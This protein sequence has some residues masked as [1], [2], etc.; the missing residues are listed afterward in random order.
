[1]AF[2]TLLVLWDLVVFRRFDWRLLAMMMLAAVLAVGR[3]PD[4]DGAP[5]PKNRRK[6]FVSMGLLGGAI[7]LSV[8]WNLLKTR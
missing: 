4:S 6:F 3:P 8:I 2:F 1:L 7:L 5:R